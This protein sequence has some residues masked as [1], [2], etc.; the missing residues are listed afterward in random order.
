VEGV[1]MGDESGSTEYAIKRVGDRYYPVIIDRE[2]G[3]HYEIKNPLTGG[4]LSYNNPEAAETYIKRAR[5]N[6]QK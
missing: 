1:E 2:A 4:I 5:E 3:G 6:E